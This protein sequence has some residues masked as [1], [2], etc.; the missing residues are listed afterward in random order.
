[1]REIGIGL[2]SLGWMGRLHAS[3]YQRLPS[4]FPELGIRPRLVVAADP[5]Q[6]NQQAAT[7]QFGF[8]RAVAKIG[9]ASCR[10]RV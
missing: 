6:E 10:E 1:M 7:E 4:R 8:E 2:V 3:S 9:R 5:I